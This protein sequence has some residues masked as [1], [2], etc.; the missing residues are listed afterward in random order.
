M[1]PKT[2]HQILDNWQTCFT[3]QYKLPVIKVRAEF[4]PQSFHSISSLTNFEAIISY[5]IPKL[6]RKNSVP[7]F[8]SG[9]TPETKKIAAREN[10][11]PAVAVFTPLIIFNL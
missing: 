10:S 1:L 7:F 3:R 4:I 8:V 9:F 5:R 11:S 6:R 2:V